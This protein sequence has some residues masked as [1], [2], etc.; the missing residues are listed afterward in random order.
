LGLKGDEQVDIEISQTLEPQ[1]KIK[2]KIHHSNGQQETIELLCRIDTTNELNYY[3]N[4][5][6]LQYVLRQMK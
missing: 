2:A 1:S 3:R 5:G 4:G 6:I